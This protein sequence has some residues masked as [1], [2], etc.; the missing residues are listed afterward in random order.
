LGNGG[1]TALTKT[2]RIGAYSR[3]TALAKLDG[4]TREAALLRTTREALVAHVGGQPS[5]VQS[6]LIERAAILALRLAVM[7][8]KAPGGALTERDAREY[9][10]W[11]N[12]YV[13]TLRE[14]GIK[15]VPERGP[16]LAEVLASMPVSGHV[17][18]ARAGETAAGADGTAA[19]PNPPSGRS[20]P[21]DAAAAGA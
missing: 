3:P 13:R 14:L 10:C 15:G 18:P 5:A 12:A 7:D 16:T 6:V 17:K 11:H 21:P 8:A 20:V 1:V 2:R 4:R 19:P 9:L